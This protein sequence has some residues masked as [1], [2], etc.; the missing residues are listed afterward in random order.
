M[1]GKQG[2]NGIAAM[3]VAISFVAACPLFIVSAACG[4]DDAAIASP[5]IDEAQWGEMGAL[6]VPL[7]AEKYRKAMEAEPFVGMTAEEAKKNGVQWPPYVV[8]ASPDVDME[9]EYVDVPLKGEKIRLPIPGGGYKV[10]GREGLDTQTDGLVF[11]IS[12]PEHPGGFTIILSK[13]P[14]PDIWPLVAL[15]KDGMLLYDEFTGGTLSEQ[16]GEVMEMFGMEIRQLFPS[17]LERSSNR[18]VLFRTSSEGGAKARPGVDA[19][20]VLY[21]GYVVCGSAQ[22]VQLL[23]LDVQPLGDDHNRAAINSW[24]Q[25]LVEANRPPPTSAIP[26]KEIPK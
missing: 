16:S 11:N 7:I 21:W 6:A 24:V 14:T 18:A 10:D 25:R 15:Y 13:A 20:I 12:P 8:P 5:T 17:A 2:R 26:G 3:V 23:I 4:G 1:I 9:I 22:F 19:A